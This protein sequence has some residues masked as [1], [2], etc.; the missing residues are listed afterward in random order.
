MIVP[1]LVPRLAAPLSC[2]QD[3]KLCALPSPT[4]C[5]FTPGRFFGIAQ[6]RHSNLAGRLR[7][8]YAALI[9][10]PR[11]HPQEQIERQPDSVLMSLDQSDI[12]A[13]SD[14]YGRFVQSAVT[15]RETAIDCSRLGSVHDNWP[16]S[17]YR[18]GN[19]GLILQSCSLIIYE[20]KFVKKVLTSQGLHMILHF[21]ERRSAPA[22]DLEPAWKMF[23]A[24][25]SNMAP[26]R[27]KVHRLRN[28]SGNCELR[29][30]RARQ[31][32]PAG[33]APRRMDYYRARSCGTR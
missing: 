23:Q 14:E 29:D 11:N 21:S 12:G 1:T 19:C 24:T 32:S 5:R 4:V 33:Q 28:G 26:G 20:W 17:D 7:R 9:D 31:L 13:I 30:R 2:L 25:M 18:D 16:S 22:A 10:L 15:Y 6:D 8:T 3:R 27:G